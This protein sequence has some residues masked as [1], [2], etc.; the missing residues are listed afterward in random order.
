MLGCLEYI[1]EKTANVSLTLM[2]D[3]DREREDGG[4]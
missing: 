1:L 3:G 4:W 2:Q